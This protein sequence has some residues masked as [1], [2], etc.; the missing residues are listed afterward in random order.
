MNSKM[1][2][3]PKEEAAEGGKNNQQEREGGGRLDEN[4]EEEE[5]GMGL[6]SVIKIH[7][8]QLDKRGKEEEMK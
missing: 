3:N 7:V 6:G 5:E 2:L 1:Q 8:T 4:E